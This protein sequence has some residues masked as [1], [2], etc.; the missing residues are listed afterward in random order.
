ML[1]PIDVLPA[2]SAL[3]PELRP[4]WDRPRDTVLNR[5]RVFTSA[6]I[7]RLGHRGGQ[8][9]EPDVILSEKSAAHRGSAMEGMRT[10]TACFA[11]VPRR[12]MSRPYMHFL[13]MFH[14]VRQIS[15]ARNQLAVN[16]GSESGTGIGVVAGFA[17][18]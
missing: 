12:C 15:K 9:R 2:Q 14:E 10:I 18:V 3:L 6:I 7:A 17:T 1:W 8:E 5:L 16:S 4:G 13:L 11:R